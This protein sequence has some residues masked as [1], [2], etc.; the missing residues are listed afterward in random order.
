MSHAKDQFKSAMDLLS[1]GNAREVL[2]WAESMIA[3]EEE[4]RRLDG[5]LCRGMVYEDGGVGVNV[6]LKA[7][8]DSYRR[9]SLIAPCSVAFAN[10]ARVCIKLTDFPRALHYLESAADYESTPEVAL[11]FARFYEERLPADRPAAKRL[12]IKAAMKGRFAGF[13]GYSRIARSLG[14]SGR[15]LAMDC[16]RV[17]LGP[18]IALLLG[19]RARYQF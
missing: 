4:S 17:L 6:D 11:G 3:S 2:L 8:L 9:V 15:A 10:L 14:Q 1:E 12:Y 7:A 19:R 13:F 18:F 16:M 5:L